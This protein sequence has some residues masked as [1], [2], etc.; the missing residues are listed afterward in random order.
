MDIGQSYSNHA[1]TLYMYRIARAHTYKFIQRIFTSY[2]INL[3]QFHRFPLV[4]C[5]FN[6]YFNEVIQQPKN[7]SNA[8]QLPLTPTKFLW[9]FEKMSA[10]WLKLI[11]MI[12]ICFLLQWNAKPPIHIGL[13][14]DDLQRRHREYSANDLMVK[15]MTWILASKLTNFN[16]DFGKL[17]LLWNVRKKSDRQRKEDKCKEDNSAP[18]DYPTK[19]L[20]NIFVWSCLLAKWTSELTKERKTFSENIH[21]LGISRKN[22][23]IWSIFYFIY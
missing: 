15:R 16:K 14:M 13:A 18:E 6:K 17:R 11:K 23:V 4:K 3:W 7:N 21:I 5:I 22:N 12:E 19:S 2:L 20:H 8:F 10:Y 1:V 9:I